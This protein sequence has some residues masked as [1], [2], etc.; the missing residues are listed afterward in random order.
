MNLNPVS[1]RFMLRSRTWARVGE[2]PGFTG[3]FLG[4]A[5]LRLSLGL[6]CL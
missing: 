1:V 2:G 3:L 4:S 5:P 6:S